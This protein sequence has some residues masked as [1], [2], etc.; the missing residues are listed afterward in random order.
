MNKQNNTDHP[1]YNTWRK[2]KEKHYSKQHN[3]MMC[4][5]WIQN[6]ST[7]LDDIGIKPDGNW[8]LKRIYL[9]KP[10]NKANV[11]WKKRKVCNKLTEEQ[12][13]TQDDTHAISIT[14]ETNSNDMPDLM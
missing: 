4:I 13:D 7:F 9:G 10:Y 11:Y 12:T 3:V 1:L 14:K 2:I 8:Y 5:E 6:F